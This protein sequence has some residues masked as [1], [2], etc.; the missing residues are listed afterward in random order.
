PLTLLRLRA[1]LLSEPLKTADT[2]PQHARHALVRLVENLR[3]ELM[4]TRHLVLLEIRPEVRDNQKE[5]LLQNRNALRVDRNQIHVLKDLHEIRFSRLLQG[6]QRRSLKTG[7]RP[8]V[9]GDLTDQT[10]ERK[11]PQKKVSRLLVA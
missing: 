3:V 8:P 5:I 1:L 2:P 6:K 10:L 11:A 4:R 9:L 7:L